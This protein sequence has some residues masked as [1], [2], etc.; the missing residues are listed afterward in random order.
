MARQELETGLC[1]LGSRIWEAIQSDDAVADAL[2]ELVDM[3][4][5]L[6]SVTLDDSCLDPDAAKAILLD[7]EDHA[8]NLARPKKPRSRQ[9]NGRSSLYDEFL[10][11]IGLSTRRLVRMKLSKATGSFPQNVESPEP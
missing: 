9:A 3:K 10:R 6:D 4:L 7:V 1:E 2:F 5:A 11:W 8:T